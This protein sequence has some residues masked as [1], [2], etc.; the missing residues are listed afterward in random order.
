MVL[1]QNTMST[2][3]ILKIIKKHKKILIWNKKKFEKLPNLFQKNFETQNKTW[4][5]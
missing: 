5:N 4:F 2:C 1:Q 3:F